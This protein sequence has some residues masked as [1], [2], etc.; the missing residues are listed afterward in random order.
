M[1]GRQDRTK[2]SGSAHLE[3]R[4]P[5]EFS[6]AAFGLTK[7]LIAAEPEERINAA[8]EKAK[9]SRPPAGALS[10]HQPDRTVQRLGNELIQVSLLIQQQARE[11]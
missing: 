6:S 2:H 8:T 11:T 10:Q 3:N 9:S 4:P 1:S 5:L 7:P